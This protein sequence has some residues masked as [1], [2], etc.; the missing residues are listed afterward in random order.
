MCVIITRKERI[1][2][3]PGKRI[4]AA[5]AAVDYLTE[6]RCAA[7]GDAARGDGS[8]T[9]RQMSPVPLAKGL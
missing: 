9:V 3:A 2:R 6:T 5:I 7:R 8:A 1:E 4:V